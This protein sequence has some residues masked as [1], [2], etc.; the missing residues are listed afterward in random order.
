MTTTTISHY[1]ILE[2]LGEGG[3][4]TV[5]RAVDTRLRR[6]V[7]IKLI[8]REGTGG[9]ESRKRFVQE[10]R[11]ASALNHPNIITIYDIGEERGADFIA[12]EYVA[13]PSLADVI[14]RGRLGIGDALKYAVQIADALAA[15]H[16]AGIVHRDLKP[17]NIVVGDKGSIK[18]L[19]FGLA[20]LTEATRFEPKDAHVST[21]TES[22]DKRLRTEEG[23]ILGTAA[24]MS[25]EQAEGKPTDADARSDVF[26]FGVVLYEMVTGRRAFR[27]DSKMSTLAAILTK[28]PE[29]P[30]RIVPGLPR[31]L[32]K[33]IVRCLR[34]SPERRWQSM[35]D[36]K[37]AL[38]ELRD[39]YESGA[40][41]APGAS[42][43][44]SRWQRPSSWTL[45]AGAIVI[46]AIAALAIGVW[47]RSR[48]PESA[49]TR[50][51]LVRLTSDVGWTDYPAISRDGKLLAFASDRSGESHLDIW[52]QQIPDGSP[53]RLTRGAGDDI[54]PSFSADGSRI[55]FH[56]SRPGGGVYVVPTLGGEA[57]LLA[58]GGYSPRFS[59]DGEWIAYGV[60]ASLGS[61]IDVAPAAGGP[62]R[63]V[64]AGFYLAQAPVWSADGRHLLFW[65]QRDRDAGPENNVDW[66][67]A[68][69][70][71]GP[72]VRTDARGVLLREGFQGFHGL[73][74]PDA[75]VGAGSRIIFH[76][77]VGDSW[78][79][80]QVPLS[81]GMWRLSGPP[82]R[83]TFGTTDEAAGSATADGRMVFI[84]RTLG[85]DVWSLPIDADRG[86]VQGAL[87]RVTEDAADDYD[88]TL[89]ADGATLVY[90]SRRAGQFDVVLRNLT[91]GAETML[92]HTP[93]DEYPAVSRDG[94]KVAYSFRQNGRMPVFVVA[95]GGGAPQQVC[96]DCGE[97]EQWSPD[98]G[99]ILYVTSD[100]PSGVG[101]LKV[102]S[103]PNGRWLKHH[104]YGIYN[105]R[106]SPDGAW[107][108]FNARP[109]RLAPAR[110]F[111]ARVQDSSVALEPDWI[112]VTD[113]GDA[114]GWSPQ[115]GLL[116][117]WSDRDGSPCLWAQ[118]LDPSTKRAAGPP[119][120]IR[121]FHSRGL[122]WKNL[123][124]G[125]PDLA[126]VRDRIVFNLGEHTGN[127]W[128][129]ELPPTRE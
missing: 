16:A 24:Y 48:T 126:V 34:K 80:W 128:M 101:F 70:S 27:G 17:G 75:W 60:A 53:V 29:P 118:R 40:L 78:N 109:D 59:P 72:G 25:P 20:K 127:V 95:A 114:P 115:G 105:P 86:R 22:A 1:E 71:G 49:A 79:M 54:D 96:D 62:S 8:R 43:P 26:S 125:A 107:V 52:V 108:A 124:L 46:V 91:T 121:H 76:G 32:E 9:V 31:D 50:P 106:F 7:A 33:A 84:S 30:S 111:V 85:A 119:I 102:G 123:Y 21:A 100:D 37:V 67:V 2:T 81:P 94:T 38:E 122:S 113:D 15:A 6:P 64:T 120:N 42:I 56:S 14:E 87:K 23:T 35:A 66:Y 4:G 82:E 74:V 77:H 104:R 110:V 63:T 99:A 28:E 18:V 61:R 112:A 129:T 51:S 90:R 58:K 69:M 13:G 57:R 44:A 3:M 68:A 103:S 19:D 97:V 83:A 116:Y 10:A 98:G 73:P 88:P 5:Y 36:L 92:T 93:A 41:A 11:A 12:M 39:E 55:A 47:R 65:G 45:V 117:F 89:S